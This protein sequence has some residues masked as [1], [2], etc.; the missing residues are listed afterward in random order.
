MTVWRRR[1]VGISRL[2]RWRWLGNTSWRSVVLKSEVAKLLV[3]CQGADRRELNELSVEV[4]FEL[5]GEL[6]FSDALE[7]VRSH[8]REESRPI[9][10]ADVVVRAKEISFPRRAT[11]WFEAFCAARG[12]DEKK[13]GSVLG[14][15]GIPFE[16]LMERADDAD[17]EPDEWVDSLLDAARG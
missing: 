1:L 5:L 8:Y 15:R 17:P 4:W 14:R 12:V 2:A 10:P 13:L 11:Q 16:E 7:A 3:W 9:F 6:E